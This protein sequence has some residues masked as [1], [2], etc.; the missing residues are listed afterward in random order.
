MPGPKSVIQRA[1]IEP[2]NAPIVERAVPALAEDRRVCA[3]DL[4][5]PSLTG[6]GIDPLPSR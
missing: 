6:V 1:R 2:S 5:S 3:A 4:I